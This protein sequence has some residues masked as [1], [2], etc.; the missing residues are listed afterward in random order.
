MNDYVIIIKFEMI[1]Y[2]A[3]IDSDKA[4]YFSTAHTII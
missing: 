2:A 4:H 3:P 1:L